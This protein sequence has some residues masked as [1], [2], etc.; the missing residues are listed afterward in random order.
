MNTTDRGTDADAAKRAAALPT[1]G[2]A[3]SVDAADRDDG[4]NTTDSGAAA[5]TRT[6]AAA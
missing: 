4:T 1:A 2:G 3:E 5:A 6:G